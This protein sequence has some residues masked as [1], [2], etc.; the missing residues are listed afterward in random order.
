MSIRMESVTDTSGREI[1]LSRVFDAPRSL[2][3]DAWTDPDQVVR[4]WGPEGFRTTTL[5]M[6]VRPLGVWRF[7]MHGPD[8][9]DFPNRIIFKEIVR[10]ERLVYLHGT[11]I[12]EDGF[13]DFLVT[14]TFVD[15]KGKTELTMRSLFATAAGRDRVV[16]DYGA[17]EGGKQH[18]ARLAEYL[19]AEGT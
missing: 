4:W 14:V 6:D 9:V 17:L 8:G 1:R 7:I 19:A 18:L 5:Q 3:F 13:E 15:R 10:P 11:G 12:D 2:V 16:R